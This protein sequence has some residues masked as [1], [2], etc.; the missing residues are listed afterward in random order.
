MPPNLST[1]QL[2]DGNP[3][4]DLPP[5]NDLTLRTQIG[6]LEQIIEFH[7]YVAG[8]LVAKAD[9]WISGEISIDPTTPS[10]ARRLLEEAAHEWT[11]LQPP[12]DNKPSVTEDNP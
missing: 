5:W 9:A 12:S 8:A 11:R 7:L 1:N 2:D 10:W 4:S 3:P 6:S